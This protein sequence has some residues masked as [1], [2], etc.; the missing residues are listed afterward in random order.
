MHDPSPVETWEHLARV[1]RAATAAMD[2]QLRER[3][4]YSLD[5]YDVLHQIADHRAPINMGE[6]ASRLLVANSSCNR[7]VGR[8]EAAGLV[9]RARSNT[10]RREVFAVLTAEGRRLRRRMAAVHTRDIDQ[11]IGDPLT[12]PQ[13][14]Q[15]NSALVAVLAATTDRASAMGA[16]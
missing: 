1:H 7:I 3:F 13:L 11:L 10:D 4:G 15:L 12:A 14:A 8:L 16:T 2:E 9:E 6:L 5:D